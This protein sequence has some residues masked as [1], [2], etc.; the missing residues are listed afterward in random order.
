MTKNFAL[1]LGVESL[2]I[3]VESEES[4]EYP[5]VDFEGAVEFK[6]AGLQLYVR[7]RF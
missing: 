3:S 5:G 4:G 7:G 1:G 2:L 6:Y